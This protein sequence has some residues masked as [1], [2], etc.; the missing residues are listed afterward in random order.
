[1][2]K[3]LLIIIIVVLA[4]V[5]FSSLYFFF[6]RSKTPPSAQELLQSEQ[7]ANTGPRSVIAEPVISPI[8]SFKGDKVWYFTSSGKLLSRTLNGG[9]TEQ[10]TLPKNIDNLVRAIWPVKTSDFIVEQN[11]GGHTSYQFYNSQ[12]HAF[13]E[14]PG[15]LRVP[16]FL[17]SGNQ[18]VYDWT[19][20]STTHELKISNADGSGFKKITGLFRPDYL[21]AASPVK[22]QVVV[23]S[24]DAGSPANLFVVDLLSG[25]VQDLAKKA[26]YQDARFS[27]DGTRLLASQITDLG[28]VLKI[29]DLAATASS[30]AASVESTPFAVN[31]SRAVWRQNGSAVI[32]ADKDGFHDYDLA[33]RKDTLFY[34]LKTGDKFI[35]QDLFLSADEQTLFFSDENSGNLYS[36]KMP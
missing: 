9:A 26:A 27:P 22:N 11:V 14:Y 21:L 25:T 6:A 17:A 10:F 16:V 33:A 28:P 31:A 32:V 12:K 29:F 5:L 34:R 2:N 23:F 35:A 13:I 24:G 4:L 19:A 18:I 3:K 8:L 15:E 7:A 30:T 36:L 20:A 1:M